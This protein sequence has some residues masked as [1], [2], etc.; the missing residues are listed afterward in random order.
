MKGN[1]TGLRLMAFED[2]LWILIILTSH[3]FQM[4]QTLLSSRFSS[5]AKVISI[6][7]HQYLLL[8]DRSHKD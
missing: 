4:I 5:K 3:I 7:G 6:H 8:E 1:I 2:D